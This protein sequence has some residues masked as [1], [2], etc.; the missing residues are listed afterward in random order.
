MK[1]KRNTIFGAV[2]CMALAFTTS[3]DDGKKKEAE[4]EA[5]KMEQEAAAEEER[6]AMQA[7]EEKMKTEA[8]E[9]SIAAKAMETESLSTLV[10]AVKAADLATMLSE[11]GEYTVFAPDN[12]AFE[13]LPAGTVE[14]L[15]KPE[16][17]E[18][19]KGLLT[20]H[21]VSGKVDAA[22]LVG[23]INDAGGKYVV[24][25][26]GGGELTAS[27]KGDS[28]ILTDANG[29]TSMVTATD[30]QASNGIVH[31]IDTVV[32]PKSC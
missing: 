24:T 26:A 6:M 17:K 27:L 22:T 16:N 31:I 13:K 32:M 10:T 7:E 28:V 5:E 14:T 4:L 23:A 3:C 25:T 2:M 19:L 18:K 11:P 21:V 15:L 9:T 30:V 29:K 1:F 12:A 20:Y 8:M